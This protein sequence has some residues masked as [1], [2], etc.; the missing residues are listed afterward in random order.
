MHA[1]KQKELSITTWMVDLDQGGKFDK[2]P[3]EKKAPIYKII[4]INLQHH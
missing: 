1:K 4:Y 2:R 3:W